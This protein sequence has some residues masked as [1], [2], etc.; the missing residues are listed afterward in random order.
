MGK[1][2]PG[3]RRSREP[4]NPLD[5]HE[6]ALGLLAVRPRSR[7]ELELRLL[8]AGLEATEVQDVLERLEGVGLIDDAQFARELAAHH[9]TV[10]GSGRRAVASALAAKGV[11]RATIDTTL[12]ELG[13]DDDA[14]AEELARDRLRRLG[15]LPPD[16]AYLRLV[17]FLARRGYDTSLARSAARAALNVEGSED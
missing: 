2:V 15:S 4:K 6:R 11:G 5:C 7:R 14:R 9:V 16:K 10:R 17:A 12:A 3:P 1:A 8:R 13:G